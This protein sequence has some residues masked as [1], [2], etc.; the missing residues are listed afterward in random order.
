MK[1][2]ETFSEERDVSPCIQETPPDLRI[3]RSENH[4]TF[5]VQGCGKEEKRK[6]KKKKRGIKSSK[7]AHARV[8]L[9]ILFFSRAQRRSWSFLP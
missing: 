1:V 9:R 4:L 6:E 7:S 3:H 5:D 8:R 2:I